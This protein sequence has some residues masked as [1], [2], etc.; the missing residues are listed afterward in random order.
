MLGAL[1]YLCIWSF[2]QPFRWLICNWRVE[3]VEHLPARPQGYALAV[4]HLHWLDIL[5]LGT[6]LPLA[7]RPHWIAKIEIFEN[8]FAAWWFR[9]MGVIPVHRG[10]R[11]LTAMKA[12]EQALQ[13]GVVL[14][15]FTEGHRSR[16]GQLQEGRG[17]A[18]RLSV[19]SG[20]PIVPASICGTE[21][22]LVGALTRKPIRVCFGEPYHP[23]VEGQTIPFDRMDELTNDMMLR[24]AAMLPEERWGFYRDRMLQSREKP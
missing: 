22:G 1:M 2:L 11:D 6:S 8:G 23:P 17:G 21:R 7:H 15:V 9:T 5:V 20:C 10:K 24:I 14:I 18:V 16:N 4:N 19:R 3:G 13:N 12:A